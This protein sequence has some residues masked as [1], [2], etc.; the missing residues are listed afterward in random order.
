MTPQR[1]NQAVHLR[2]TNPDGSKSATS[3]DLF[4]IRIGRGGDNDLVLRDRNAS[5]HHAEIR[6]VEGVPFVRDLNSLNGLRVNGELVGEAELQP[7]DRIQ[8]GDTEI[9]L[10]DTQEGPPD[11]PRP[12]GWPDAEDDSTSSAGVLEVIRA[13]DVEKLLSRDFPLEDSRQ[14]GAQSVTL[15]EFEEKAAKVN[16]AYSHLFSIMDLVSSIGNYTHIEQ[17]CEQFIAALRKVFPLIE[18]VAIVEFELDQSTLQVVYQTGFVRPFVAF[19]HPS[20]S[21]LRR[22]L[23]EMRAVYAVDARRDPRF[24]ESES[25]QARGVRSMMCAPLVIR[26]EVRGAIYVENLSQPYCFSQFDLNFLTI[27]AFHLGMAME[28]TRALAERD[29]AFERA[30][31]TMKAVKQD[32]TALLLQYSQSERKFR[33]LF[34]QSALGAAVIDLGTGRIE[35]VNDGLVRMIGLNR[36]QL[37]RMTYGD[38]L[39]EDDP[40]KAADWLRTVRERGEGTTKS[41]LKTNRGDKLVTLESCRALRVG[42]TAVMAAYF[43]DITAQERAEEATKTQLA[44][45]TALSE[46][47]QSLMR[48][49]DPEAVYPLLF[50]RMRSVMEVDEFHLAL[51]EDGEPDM[52]VVF[53]AHKTASD[54]HTFQH[55]ATP[56]RT[57]H[58][59]VDRALTDGRPVLRTTSTDDKTDTDKLLEE[60]RGF[61]FGGIRP[62]MLLIPFEPHP[63]L[64]GLVCVQ[65]EGE[66]AYDTSHVETATALVAQASLALSNAS[67]FRSL[68]DQQ[69]S[70]R[71]LSQQI[72]TAQE[73]ERGRISRELHDGV[74]QQLAAMKY[75]L[76]AIRGAAAAGDTA[77]LHER[78][79]EAREL[80]KQIIE[81]LRTISL[82]LRPTMLDDLGLKPTMEWFA[83]KFTERYGIKL[84]IAFG[85]DETRISSEGATTI[86]R[87][88]QEALGNIAKH[89]KATSATVSLTGRPDD[90]VRI[91]IKDDGIGFDS[92]R[93]PH[94]QAAEG[95]SGVLNMKERAHFLGGTFHLDTAPAK[96]TQLTITIPLLK[97]TPQ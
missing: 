69:E 97:E 45:V 63:S 20:R 36:R 38:L 2:I 22:V 33:A 67:A 75:V 13:L 34:E 8:V 17:L 76:E 52:A 83:R 91:E 70:M 5:R 48:T 88:V 79:T 23:Y 58:S 62:S 19:T 47:S 89:S 56:I 82:D 46:L 64:R 10:V 68:R 28:T 72:M 81:D 27:F 43:I 14:L 32:K 25:M 66:D 80:A 73:T 42:E 30:L 41:I 9:F 65:S 95:C 90:N 51:Q 71:Q 54:S 49:L 87:I 7:G 3:F 35:E 60:N 26:G 31:E 92:S 77:K 74:G 21:V 85:V 15:D 37:A 86:F 6:R 55:R 1:I 94:K 59:L 50:E 93:L 40:Q 18:N 61:P 12:S 53:S 84:D 29:R 16:Q 4:P 44:R 24:E 11:L 96:G 78:I 57:T 39:L